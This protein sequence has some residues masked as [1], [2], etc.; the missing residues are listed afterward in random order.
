MK[1]LEKLLTEFN[2]L[3]ENKPHWNYNEACGFGMWLGHKGY[4]LNGQEPNTVILNSRYY[5]ADEFIN[6]TNIIL[7]KE[8]IDTELE[9]LQV[10]QDKK[11]TFHEM[12]WITIRLQ[13]R[14]NELN[15]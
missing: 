3:S 15:R 4:R 11:L 5:K 1:T 8:C 13:D 2:K 14:L 9:L 7:T 10:M 6:S 12:T